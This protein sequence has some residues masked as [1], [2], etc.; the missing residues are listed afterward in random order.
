MK[1]I[2]I[3]VIGILMFIVPLAEAQT[4]NTKSHDISISIPEVA[5]LDLE[6]PASSAS[7]GLNPL[8]PNEAGN[9]LDFANVSNNEIWLNYSS[10][11]GSTHPSRKV[12]AFVEGAIPNGVSLYVSASAYSGNGNGKNG[13][14]AGKV[15][16]SNKMQDIITNIGSCYTGNGPNNGHRLTYTLELEN[17]YNSYAS[18][19][20]DQSST[21]SVTYIL[22][23]FN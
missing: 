18:L 21:I 17:S 14:P 3:G 1:G 9:S 11:I 10:V 16:L 2:S 7:I 4:S 19:N 20:F 22:S 6:S 13:T 12:S 15:S 5:L 8:A 23:D